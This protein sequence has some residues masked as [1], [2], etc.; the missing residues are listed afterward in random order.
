MDLPCLLRCPFLPAAQGLDPLHKDHGGKCVFLGHSRQGRPCCLT[1]R[2]LALA[3]GPLDCGRSAACRAEPAGRVKTEPH[4]CPLSSHQE[5]KIEIFLNSSHRMPP[6]GPTPQPHP[7]LGRRLRLPKSPDAWKPALLDH[8][9]HMP[10]FAQDASEM[11]SFPK[12]E[13]MTMAS[14]QGL[15]QAS[16]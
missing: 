8:P 9:L 5:A 11:G 13:T 3:S 15:P 14:I 16:P 6:R 7:L 12:A 10:A 4:P 2:P 1:R